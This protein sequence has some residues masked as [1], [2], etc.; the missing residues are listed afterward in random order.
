MVQ[1]NIG[2][3]NHFDMSKGLMKSFRDEKVK[4]SL[5]RRRSSGLGMTVYEKNAIKKIS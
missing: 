4:E 3:M 5:G 1:Q 2:E